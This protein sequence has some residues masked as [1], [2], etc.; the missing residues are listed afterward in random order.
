M[1]HGT[2]SG[3]SVTQ[4]RI[5]PHCTSRP[6]LISTP[7][8]TKLGSLIDKILMFHIVHDFVIGSKRACRMAVNLI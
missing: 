8:L 2:V 1:L 4:G 7:N 5:S 3:W 6:S